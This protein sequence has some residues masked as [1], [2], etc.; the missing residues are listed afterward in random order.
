[1]SVDKTSQN[2]QTAQLSPAQLKDPRETVFSKIT[3][4]YST[5]LCYAIVM[6]IVDLGGWEE[7]LHTKNDK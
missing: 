4:F 1:M 7:N 6:Q 2:T 5:S 3:L